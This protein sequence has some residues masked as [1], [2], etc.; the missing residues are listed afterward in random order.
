MSNED[1]KALGKD[2]LGIIIINLILIVIFLLPPAFLL[3]SDKSTCSVIH[4]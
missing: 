1:Q 4:F 2:P 3:L